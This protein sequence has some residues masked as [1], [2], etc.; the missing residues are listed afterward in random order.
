M[1]NDPLVSIIIYNFNYGK[2]LRE[3]VESAI[4]QTYK[5]IEIIMS[6]NASTDDS[7]ETFIEIERNH[8][9]K[10]FIAR[11][12]QNFGTDHNFAVCWAARKGTYHVVLGSDDVLE[13]TFVE[14]AVQVMQNYPDIGYVMC[15]RSILDAEGKQSA[16]VPFYDR[17]CIIYPPGQ[18]LVYMMAAVNPSISQVLYRSS[19]LT[20]QRSGTGGLAGKY[21][22]T[23]ILDFNI[24]IEFPVA[25]LKEPLIR[26]RLHG[27]NQ[28]LVASSD[29]MEVIGFYVLNIQFAD[30]GTE[31]GI[32]MLQDN[33]EKSTEKLSQLSLR[34]SLRSLLNDDYKQAKRY[35]YLAQALNLN[36]LDTEFGIDLAS[37][38]NSNA[39]Q[40]FKQKAKSLASKKNLVAREVSYS[41]P[42]PFQEI[43]I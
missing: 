14:K 9:G 21:Y 13:P 39:Q 3:C 27:N 18:S 26:H 40:N 34:Y 19:L 8:K 2:Y 29:L 42:E 5:N 12:Y 25:Y 24:S 22:A 36:I 10:V 6:D 15:H 30:K 37:I 43:K 41:P 4:N 35:F 28:S 23:R 20:S 33:L 1:S 17:S 11:N 7:W 32:P 31:L 38:F 16:E